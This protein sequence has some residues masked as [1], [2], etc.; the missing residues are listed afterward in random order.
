MIN[1]EIHVGGFEE[2]NKF[3]P[4]GS[5]WEFQIG[6]KCNPLRSVRTGIKQ[7]KICFEIKL[8]FDSKAQTA[9]P[10]EANN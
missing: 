5:Q 6:T 7:R 10:P 2:I 3:Q 4:C 9:I 8:C 1:P